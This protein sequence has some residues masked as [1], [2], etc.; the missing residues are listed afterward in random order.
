MWF[1]YFF[2]LNPLIL[3]AGFFVALKQQSP[4]TAELCLDCGW[5]LHKTA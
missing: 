3:I 5:R 4:A 1:F 2:P